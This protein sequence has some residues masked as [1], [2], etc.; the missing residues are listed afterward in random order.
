MARRSG[1]TIVKQIA[2]EIDRATRAQQRA[3]IA[4]HK[5]VLR[6]EER[7]QRQ[8]VRE[9]DTLVR[10]G[11]RLQEQFNR[12]INAANT[13]TTLATKESKLGYPRKAGHFMLSVT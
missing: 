6:E 10:Q 1:W 7:I 2:R 12:T 3:N 4:H 8:T 13:A 9:R 5:A 11:A